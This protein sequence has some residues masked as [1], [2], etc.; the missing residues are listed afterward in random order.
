MGDYRRKTEE[1]PDSIEQGV[2]CKPEVARPS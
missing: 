2:R 1:S